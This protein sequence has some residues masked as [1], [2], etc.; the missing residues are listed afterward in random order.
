MSNDL[1]VVCLVAIVSR[2][3]PQNPE[4]FWAVTLSGTF[5][6]LP[7]FLQVWNAQKT[8][9]YCCVFDADKKETRIQTP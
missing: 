9:C 5:L 8:S 4:L 6:L 7:H 3:E 1:F 2:L